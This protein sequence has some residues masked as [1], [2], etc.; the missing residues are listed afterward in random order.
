MLNLACITR[1]TEC[2]TKAVVATPVYA[3][4]I[5]LGYSCSLDVVKIEWEAKYTI[6]A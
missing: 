2:A 4:S 5:L 1:D 6:P 3:M